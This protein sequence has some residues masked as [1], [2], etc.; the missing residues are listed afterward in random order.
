MQSLPFIIPESGDEDDA[1]NT[2]GSSRPAK[3]IKIASTSVASVMH[4]NY[5]E[6]VSIDQLLGAGKF[7]KP[8]SSTKAVLDVESFNL[9]KKEWKRGESLDLTMRINLPLVHSEMLI[10]VHTVVLPR[11][12]S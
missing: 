8:I 4:S 9:V 5:P 2:H 7:V 11:N 1:D 3:R 12:G 10:N 6:S